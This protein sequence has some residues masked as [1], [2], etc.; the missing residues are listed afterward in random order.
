MDNRSK[1]TL[2]NSKIY[3]QDLQRNWI[4]FHCSFVFYVMTD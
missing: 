4:G 2:Q 3:L 1:P